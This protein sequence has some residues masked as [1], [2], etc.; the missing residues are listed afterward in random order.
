MYEAYDSKKDIDSY[1]ITPNNSLSDLSEESFNSYTPA[2]KFTD[3]NISTPNLQTKFNES[4]FNSLTENGLPILVCG[5]ALSHCVRA[6]TRD[7]VEA[8]YNNQLT[9]QVIL[10]QNG[11]SSV[12][13]F[14]FI[15][16]SLVSVMRDSKISIPVKVNTSVITIP[17]VQ[18]GGKSSRR[19]HPKKKAGKRRSSRR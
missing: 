3:I 12:G 17:E 6:S 7:I 10:I 14:D 18:A 19:R 16:N 4:L 1:V 5:E 13:G 2:T 11:A 8:I 9:N 15:G